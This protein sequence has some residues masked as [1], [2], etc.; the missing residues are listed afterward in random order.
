MSVRIIKTSAGEF[1]SFF[2]KILKRGEEDAG[3][4]DEV[5]NDILINVKNKG[6]AALLEYTARFDNFETTS[7]RLKVSEEEIEEAFNSI[8]GDVKKALTIAAERI[9]VFHEKQME[10]SWTSEDEQGIVLG[11]LVRP[12]EKV[13]IYVP[14]GKAAY[15][16]SVLMNAIPARVAGV[17]QI[18]MVVPTPGGE[19]NGYLLAAAYAAFQDIDAVVLFTY[20][21][22]G[23]NFVPPAKP[24]RLRGWY[25]LAHESRALAQMHVAA[26]VFRRGDV[27]PAQSSITVPVPAS[28]GINSIINGEP[29]RKIETVL[30]NPDYAGA[31]G[32]NTFSVLSG[33][34]AKLELMPVDI[35]SPGELPV[36]GSGRP[37]SPFI[38]DT[39]ELAW[40]VNRP[41]NS[42]LLLDT[43]L[44]KAV[45]GFLD[46]NFKLDGL[47]IRGDGGSS[48]F[49]M[50]SITALDGK[51]IAKSQ[52]MLLTTVGGAR[53]RN[54]RLV[55]HGR[56][57]RLCVMDGF[58]GC[59]KP[60]WHISAGPLLLESNPATVRLDTRGKDLRVY[61]LDET[62]AP[63]SAIPI[64]SVD[65]EI[66]FSVGTEGDRT[67]WYWIQAVQ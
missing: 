30:K 26:N 19:K 8:D 31:D 28:V 23:G 53:N 2:Q 49:G 47:T 52:S 62:G 16:S 9:R 10:K 3:N 5:V 17:K 12:L 58:D 42:Y 18:I 56:G 41:G 43:K 14:G 59:N 13:G 60:F 51:Q 50:V 36:P 15:P 54:T 29:L 64:R 34:L 6:D 38:S 45:T 1:A 55:P 37:E 67:P 48:Q 46:R 44:T 65:G 21:P 4:V 57:V 33:L 27:A 20:N 66:E 25:T 32:R 11:Q 39:G 24:A 61:R 22:A 35:A 40:H 63:I 7:E